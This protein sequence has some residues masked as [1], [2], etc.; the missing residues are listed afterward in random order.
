MIRK[1]KVGI[2]KS[3][4]AIL[5]SSPAL[6]LDIS[7][8]F[9]LIMNVVYIA[10]NLASALIYRSVWSATVTAYHSLFV[11]IRAYLIRS[12][13][14]AEMGEVS[15]DR[16]NQICLRIGVILLLLDFSALGMM[17]YTIRRGRHVE[18]SGIVLVGFLIYTVY[19]LISSVHGMQKWS[20]DNKT[21]HFATK[22]ITLAA[23]LMSVFNLQYSL[24]SSIGLDSASIL[25]VGTAG[26]VI[27]FFTIIFLAYRLIVK[28]IALPDSQNS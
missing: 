28:N 14:S 20:N 1:K 2:L 17:L 4:A 15:S 18:Y 9:G 24:L 7:L 10:E 12:R 3:L 6:R 25:R 8:H 16:I 19:S 11:I 26:G 22:N 5:I 23:A 21:L 27:I 13:R